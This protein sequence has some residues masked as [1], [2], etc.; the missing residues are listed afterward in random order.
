M[1]ATAT[2]GRVTKKK[3]TFTQAV[4]QWVKAKRAMERQ[5]ALLE[6]A[7]P[8][9]EAGME[10]RDVDEYGDVVL[11]KTPSKLILDQPKVREFLGRQLS[12][13]Q[14]RTEPSTSL[15]LKK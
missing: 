10:Q 12:R 15:S 4:E 7:A 11:I 9:V 8:I 14:K 2:P 3:L 6:E 13:F 5:K 1:A